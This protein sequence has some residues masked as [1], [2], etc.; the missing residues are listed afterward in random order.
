MRPK[1]SM[2]FAMKKRYLFL[3]LLVSFL[4]ACIPIEDKFKPFILNFDLEDSYFLQ[5][6]ILIAATLTDDIGIETVIVSVGYDDPT[7]PSAWSKIDSFSTR[8]GRVFN[9][10]TF[11]VVPTRIKQGNYFMTITVRDVGG[12]L[13]TAT[14]NFQILGDARG[15]VFSEVLIANMPEDELGAPSNGSDFGGSYL[16]CANQSVFF[17]GT[18][19]DNL[20]IAKLEAYYENLPDGIEGLSESRI[21]DNR[22]EVSMENIFGDDLKIPLGLTPEDK[23]L[24]VL[25]A[26]DKDG[27]TSRYEFDLTIDE[28][29]DSEAPIVNV[30]ETFPDIDLE[31]NQAS[32]VQGDTLF[33]TAVEVTDNKKIRRFLAKLR[34]PTAGETVLIDDSVDVEALYVPEV[35][36][37]PIPVTARPGSDFEL[38]LLAGDDRGNVS[39]PYSIMIDVLRDTPPEIFV[40]TATEIAP[41]GATRSLSLS[42][43]TP[44]GIKENRRLRIDGKIKEDI[45][46]KSIKILWGAAGSEEEQVN[47][48][49]DDLFG[50]SIYDFST[51]SNEYL[52]PDVAVGTVLNLIIEASDNRD[53]TVKIIYK[54]IIE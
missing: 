3:F 5:D 49:E 2:N 47:L 34:T 50:L 23:F 53:Q 42:T 9:L 52:V 44:V 43:V 46:F 40:T 20:G 26:T 10:D 1:Y 24:L 35:I 7:A 33:V 19:T 4:G 41:T 39:E 25:E 32:I 13:E 15:P 11:F 14:E 6:S 16:A 30:L 22:E 8:G 54:F 48:S 37:V 28:D 29:C 17:T 45:A 38:I 21:L 36:A 12:N 31:L 51:G 27:N 18:L